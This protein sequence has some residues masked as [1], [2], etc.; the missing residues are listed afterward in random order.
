MKRDGT[1]SSGKKWRSFQRLSFDKKQVLKRV[2]K[3]ER[4]SLR[5]AHKFIVRR[6]KNA[7]EVRRTIALWVV[8]VAVIIGAVGLQVFWDQQTYR[9]T[10]GASGGTYAEASIGP[11]NTLNPLYAA[12]PAELVA[13]Q[14]LFSRLMTYDKTGNLN[15]DLARSV[16]ASDDAKSYTIK[17]RDDVR[18][19]DDR[20]LTAEDVIFTIDLMKDPTTRSQI[21]G[22]EGV[23]VEK[24]D[25]YTVKFTLTTAYAPFLSALTFPVL[26]AHILKE[27]DH[28]ALRE[29]GFSNQPVGSGP[30]S[31]RLLQDI[32]SAK[33]RRVT[34][35]VANQNYYGGKPKL[36]RYQIHAYPDSDAIKKAL[37]MNEVNAAG[38]LN[39]A[40]VTT[41]E[42]AQYK[43]VSQPVRAG[44]YAF[45]N[46]ESELLSDVKVR[47]A[48]Q[49]GTDT[50]KVRENVGNQV[51]A[52][53][54]PLTREQLSGDDIPKPTN[55]NV[56]EAKKLL[57]E[58]GWIQEGS[59]RKK[60]GREL[61]LSVVTTKDRDYERALEALIGQWQTN[62]GVRVD[63]R[64]VDATDPTQSFVQSVL[65]QRSYDV[66]LYQ[67]VIGGDPDV[68]EFWHSSQAVARGRNLSNYSNPVADDILLSARAAT[69]PELRLA[70]YKAFTKQWL[71]DAPAIGLYQSTEQYAFNKSVRGVNDDMSLVTADSRY[72]TVRDWTVGDQTV[73]KTP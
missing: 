42:D 23:T 25:D 17:L 33:G 34:H 31:F 69:R 59:I 51:P 3:A 30:F 49:L 58:A 66:L 45:L 7:R 27:V 28:S 14:L 32:D 61:R 16:V 72:S 9:T 57:D 20:H 29:D 39:R 73:Y 5:H 2:R 38:G 18:W 70:K 22:W 13:S 62:L 37:L 53:S 47:R 4:S 43:V 1:E 6:W 52:L 40:D 8:S 21:R 64:I 10:V 71:E 54:L 19:H 65:Q 67:I 68:Y 48:L 26:P 56:D 55:Y 46:N 12:S 11:I 35:L 36:E 50:A 63:A 44:V 41:V 15:Y 60:D 24:V